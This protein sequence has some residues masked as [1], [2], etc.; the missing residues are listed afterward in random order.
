MEDIK[1]LW[2]SSAYMWVF[3]AEWIF[4]TL[5]SRAGSDSSAD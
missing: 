3:A 5:K 2:A 4:L 1:R